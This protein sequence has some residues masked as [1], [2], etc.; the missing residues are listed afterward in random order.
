MARSR[1]TYHLRKDLQRAAEELEAISFIRIRPE[2][3]R[4]RK[5]GR[6]TYEVIFEKQN[7]RSAYEPRPSENSPLED[8]PLYS[9]LTKRGVGVNAARDIIASGEFS[10]ARVQEHI[11]VHDWLVKNRDVRISKNSA[12]FLVTSIRENYPMPDGFRSQADIKSRREAQVRKELARM[13]KEQALRS[14]EQENFE[15]ERQ[16][17]LDYLSKLPSDEARTE[18]E[19]AAVAKTKSLWRTMYNEAKE[20]GG[21]RYEYLSTIILYDYVFENSN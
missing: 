1:E 10:D 14:Q 2:E 18:L 6:G 9:A 8:H 16:K 17:V 7:A 3:S 21:E 4:F 5:V 13:K 12:G 15:T 11:E 19:R 20:E